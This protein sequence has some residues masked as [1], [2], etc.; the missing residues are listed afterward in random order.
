[1]KPS[2]ILT[3][4]SVSLV[5]VLA[6]GLAATSSATAS[7]AA[8]PGPPIRHVI[9][10]MI[11]NHSFDN[12]FGR[13][14][15]ADGIPAGTSLLNPDA[16]D[17]SAPAVSPV[18]ATPN[19]GDVD[20]ALNNSAVAE[21]MAMDY[22][23]GQGYLMDHYTVFPQDGLASIT[24]FGPRFDPDEQY[25]A[26]AYELADHNFQPVIAPT[27]PNVMTA[28]N[29]TDHGWVYNNL[30]PAP[31]QPWNSI[32]DELTAYGRSWKIYYALPLPALDGSI[33]PQLIPAGHMADL[34]TG[35]AFFAALSAGRLPDFSFLR[36]G[37]GYSTEPA[38]DI[39]EGDAWVGQ[40]VN[41]VAHS[42]YWASTA[43][44]LTYDESGGFWDHVPPP[45]SAGYGP[46]TPLVIISPYARRGVFSAQTTNVSVLSFLQRLWDMPALTPLNARQND[47]FSAFDF[48]QRPL[49]PPS[50]PVAPADT[51]GFHARGGILTD[52]G[53]VRPGR[54]V[55]VNLEAET[56]GLTLDSSV[57]GPV[58]LSL[59]PPPG[60]A[61]PASF[62]RSA[63]LARGLADLTVSF[64][65]A[66]YYRI[67]A[68]GPGGSKGWITLDVGVTPDTAP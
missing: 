16:Y 68:T 22:R 41:A 24:E 26:S 11:E 29:G 60:V 33:W 39:G 52:V 65:E 62:R 1:V 9:E 64:P 56:A 12:L 25:L 17:V 4:G 14:P 48:G 57:S 28:L 23:P 61:V 31:T 63:T 54:S 20:G 58:S 40:V 36:P 19:E 34:T 5:S 30:E 49:A 67:V 46:R 8:A 15:G 51:I 6:G 18:W 13:F 53:P 55:T 45:A 3:A 47:L 59:T 44:F 32:F 35:Q 21:Q 66:G 37:V 2:R 38:E 50:V 43:I 42:K 27:Q 10:I 7:Q